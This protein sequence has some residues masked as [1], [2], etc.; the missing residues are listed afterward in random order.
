M[1]IF[2]E[3][4]HEHITM[5]DLER[6]SK[7]NLNEAG[8]DDIDH[9]QTVSGKIKGCHECRRRVIVAVIMRKLFGVHIWKLKQNADFAIDLRREG[10]LDLLKDLG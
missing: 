8:V 1:S 10:G 9:Y 4:S 6:V 3:D 2:H 5:E 7:F